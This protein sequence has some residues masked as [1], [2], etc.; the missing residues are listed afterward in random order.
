M[1]KSAIEQQLEA[2]ESLVSNEDARRA[3]EKRRAAAGLVR[4]EAPR[5]PQAPKSRRQT[6]RG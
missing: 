6:T 4:E 5:E 2:E 1:S 3:A